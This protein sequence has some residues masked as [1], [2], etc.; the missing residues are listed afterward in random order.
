MGKTR[1]ALRITALALA[2][3]MA[4]AGAGTAQGAGPPRPMKYV[5]LG[6]SVAAGIGAGSPT[7]NSHNCWINE[8]AKI[9]VPNSTKAYPRR[10]AAALGAQLDFQA[11]CGATVSGVRNNQTRT[12]SKRT[13]LVTVQVGAND[14][15]FADVLLECAVLGRPCMDDLRW[16]QQQ[17]LNVLPGR[18]DKLY[19]KIGLKAKNAKVV[20]VGYPKLV[21]PTF[22]PTCLGD[23]GLPNDVRTEMNGAAHT[24]NDVLRIEAGKH[25]FDFAEVEPSFKGHAICEDPEWING[26][27]NPL[28]ESYHPNAAGHQALG[29]LVWQ[30]VKPTAWNRP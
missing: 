27:S 6:D 25:E 9:R 1:S 10:V 23:G 2:G 3:A 8:E 11:Y 14:F 12:L 16:I 18:L 21:T 30:R 15:G 29:W 20:V 17:Y 19:D 28:V 13:K 5:A 7:A 4:V 22:N 26:F 24:L